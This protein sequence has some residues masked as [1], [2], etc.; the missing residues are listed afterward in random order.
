MLGPDARW[1]FSVLAGA[2]QIAGV[3][4]QVDSVLIDV[5]IG[6][7]SNSI[8]ERPCDKEARRL[9]R[10]MRGSS[11]FPAPARE[12]LQASGYRQAVEINRGS[13]GR[14]LSRQSWGIAGKIREID[15]LL[16]RQPSLRGRI[17]ECH[18][19]VCFWALNGGIA[20]RYNKKTVGGRKERIEVLRKHFPEVDGLFDAACRAFRR[21]DLARDDV[22]D[23]LVVAVS[24]R[25]GYGAC[26]TVPVTPPQDATGLPMEIVYWQ[27][28]IKSS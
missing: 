12:A 17:R 7:V 27:P 22:L 5:P 16:R 6:L 19:E 28:H 1:E 10:P 14:G 11:V 2:E 4:E 8:E 21:K 9:L 26:D 20:M 25:G 13:A 15:D 3:A 23:A 18:P 24:A